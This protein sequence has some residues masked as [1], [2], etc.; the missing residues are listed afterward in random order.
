M[1][2]R[3]DLL[4]LCELALAG[5]L[6]GAAVEWDP[7]PAV[8]VVMASKGYPEGATTGRE[9]FGLEDLEAGRCPDLKVFHAGTRRRAGRTLTN[10]G[11]VLCVT[12]LGSNLARA[13]DK[14]YEAVRGPALRDPVLPRRHR[15]RGGGSGG[16]GMNI[17]AGPQI[18][19]NRAN[20]LG[21]GGGGAKKRDFEQKIRVFLF[22]FC[23]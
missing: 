1:R 15:P 23:I 21:G 8:G 7:R 6:D 2:L 11:R 3:S 16:W 17:P 22:L 13:R 20:F 19:C 14:A 4:A 5:E 9:I 18:P 10:G 12:A